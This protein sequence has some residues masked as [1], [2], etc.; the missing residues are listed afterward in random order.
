M[1][2]TDPDSLSLDVNGTPTTEEVAI[3]TGLKTLQLRVAGN[4]DDTAPG[5]TSGVTGKAWYS[6]LKEE[7]LNG[8]DASTLRRF[9]FP[10]KMIFEGSFIITNGWTLADQQTRD[11]IR[12]AGFQDVVDATEHACMIALGAMDAP[13]SDLAYYVKASGFTA[14]TTDYDKT[15]ELNENV[16]ITGANTYFKSFL[17]EPA[18]IYGEYNL[19]D[20]Q[21]LSALN[22]QAYSF[23]L[24]N[25]PDLKVSA[26]DTT[27]DTTSPYNSMEINYIK[28]QGFE[29]WAI[30]QVYAAEMVVQDSGGRWWFTAAG[31]TSAGNDSDLGGGSDTGITW[32]AYF[33]EELIGSTYYAF[34]REVDANG[35]SEIEAHEF[36][37]RQL[38]QAGDINDDTGITAGQ[39]TYGTVNGEVARQLTGFVGDTLLLEPGVVIRNFDTN[40]TNRINHQPITV[41]QGG[42]D[43]DDVPLVFSTVAYPFVSAGSF[44]FSANIVSQP[45]VDTVYTVYF[46][47]ITEDTSTGIAT[48]GPTGS[49]AT[50]DYSAD[51]GLLDHY[52]NGDYFEMSNFADASLN[53][54]WQADGNPT[55]NTILAT[56]QDGATVVAEA[57]GASVT[58]RLNPFESPGAVIVQENDTTP[59]DAQV[60]AASIAWDFD[61]TNNNQG[62]RTANTPAPCTIVAIAKDGAEWAEANFTITAATGLEV[63]VNANDE[64]NY[65]NA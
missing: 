43:A 18:K 8:T 9:K 23:P 61:Y 25:E 37:Q 36:C 62:G 32:V 40:S 4:L 47:W 60:S 45:D 13:L 15:G 44:N 39:G 26:N 27:I 19:L 51:A 20:E 65:E 31:G 57:A 33:G 48:T 64:R 55:S 24:E 41:D 49:Q 22:F 10:I 58:A 16:D 34:N 46:D 63:P 38:R 17:R 5:K 42:L 52:S 7:W 1:K 29:T 21:G 35:G 11:L 12:D 28:G 56:K 59:M 14:A 50:I 3:D 2:I 54:L 53:G 6:F 30:S